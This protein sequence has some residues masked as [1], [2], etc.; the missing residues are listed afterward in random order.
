MA[1]T[2]ALPEGQRGSLVLSTGL[3]RDAVTRRAAVLAAS[4]GVVIKLA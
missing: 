3:A 1:Q 2:I 4:E